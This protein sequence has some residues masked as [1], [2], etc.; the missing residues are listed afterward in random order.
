L[1]IKLDPPVQLKRI[2]QML[3][4]QI[5][6]FRTRATQAATRTAA[7]ARITS[8]LELIRW[9]DQ[10]TKKSP[11]EIASDNEMNFVKGEE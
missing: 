5:L 6:R 9:P 3:L 2:N 7:S 8:E 11:D 4:D 10:A 1:T